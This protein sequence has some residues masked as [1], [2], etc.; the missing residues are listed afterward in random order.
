MTYGTYSEFGNGICV[1]REVVQRDALL[2]LV[3]VDVATIQGLLQLVR[4]ARL[5]LGDLQD[6][7]SALRATDKR[8]KQAY[9]Y[10]RPSK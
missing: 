8:A 2:V 10:R 9:A 4:A 6:D 7:A 3:R 1:R 5:R